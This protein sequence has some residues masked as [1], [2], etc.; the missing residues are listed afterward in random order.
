MLLLAA[1]LGA[2]ACKHEPPEGP[3]IP[4]DGPG[5]PGPDEPC[6]AN[7]VYFQQDILPLLISN[8]S[9]PECHS[10]NSP[11]DGIDLTSY[12]SL[13]SAG[14]VDPF[15]L[16]EDLFEAITDSDPDD[17]MPRPPAPPL[18]QSQIDLIAA[19]IMQGAQNNSCASAG[20][21]TLNVTYSGTI[22]PLVQQRCQG[23]HSGATPQGGLDLGS[24]SVLNAL[25]SDGRLGGSVQHAS[26]AIPMPPSGPRLPDCNVRQFMIWIDNG[27]PNN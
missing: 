16:N 13:M 21:D 4:P 1:T 10:S 8:C 2:T 12:Q 26:G 23:C 17:R 5:G 19:W 7:T 15:D 25:A 20:C 18:S 22:A 24:W 9:M 14:I 6:D 11:A 3:V 27:A